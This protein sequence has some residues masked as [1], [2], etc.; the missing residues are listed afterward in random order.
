VRSFQALNGTDVLTLGLDGNL[1]REHAPFG[2]PPPAREQVDALVATFQLVD[3]D[4]ILVLDI[5]GHL[6]R[7]EAPFGSSIPPAGPSIDS[8]VTPFGR[9]TE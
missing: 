5:D 1:W 4:H 3:L 6:R 7:D 2:T 9:S 8:D